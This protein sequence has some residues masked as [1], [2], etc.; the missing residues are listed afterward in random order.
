MSG[1]Q[2]IEPTYIVDL[3]EAYVHKELTDSG[4]YSNRR[5]LDE[6]G[7]FSLHRLAAEIYAGGYQDGERSEARR[8]S[9]R[10]LRER[11]IQS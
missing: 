7:V 1:E 5:P 6:S 11:E 4:E 10:I 2:R 9:A 3:V 8:V